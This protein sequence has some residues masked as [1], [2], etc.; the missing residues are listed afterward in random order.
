MMTFRG[1][2]LTAAL[3]STAVA[4]GGCNTATPAST[5]VPSVP[6]G[7]VSTMTSAGS[8]TTTQAT[9]TSAA[10]S[11]STS[12]EPAT[13]TTPTSPAAAA[14]QRREKASLAGALLALDDLPTGWSIEK[15][16]GGGGGKLSSTTDAACADLN[17]LLNA[18]GPKGS[19][20]D[21]SVGIDGG[22]DGPLV[23]ERLDAMGT[24][25]AATAVVGSL[26][27]AAD[28]CRQLTVR[29]PDGTRARMRLSEVRAPQVG[30]GAFALRLTAS[31]GDYDGL[32]I[33]FL[34]APL[35][36]VLLSFTFFDAYPEELEGLS[37]DAEAKVVEKLRLG[38]QTT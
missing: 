8:S 19:L 28:G 38:G 24:S 10:T 17:D 20:A 12:T 2:L 34:Y 35:H 13:P 21:A 1:A 3:L 29:L 30:K 9:T 33:T 26:R 27:D 5:S 31:G 6:S 11:S 22:Q 36:D 7:A 14:P 18:D 37:K 4:V 16:T 25:A 23:S 15:D 32:E